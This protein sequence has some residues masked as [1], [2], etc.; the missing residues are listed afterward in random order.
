MDANNQKLENFIT[1]ILQIQNNERNKILKAK[2]LKDIAFEMGMSESEWQTISD[3][4]NAHALRGKGFL[5]YKNWGD[6]IKEF[7]Q[8]HTLNPYN[9]DILYGLA[10]SHKNLW[11]QTRMSFHKVNAEKY[12]QTCIGIDPEYKEAIALISAL[13]RPNK[14]IQTYTNQGNEASIKSRK[15]NTKLILT[16]LAFLVIAG[17]FGALLFMSS[18][19]DLQE[20]PKPESIETPKEITPKDVPPPIE[21]EE[22]SLDMILVENDKSKGIS[23]ITESSITSDYDDSYSVKAKGYFLLKDIE[24]D[25][26]K[27]KIDVLDQNNKVILTDVKKLIDKSDLIVRSGDLVPFDFLNY[28][29]EANMPDFKVIRLSV[30]YIKKEEGNFKYKASKPINIGWEIEKPTNFD[31]SIRERL[32]SIS[33]SYGTMYH[34]I[35]L[36]VENTGNST[37]NQLQLQIK[38]FNKQ[39]KVVKTEEIYITIESYSPLKRGTVYLYDRVFGIKELTLKTYKSYSVSVLS[40]K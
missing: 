20:T 8:A 28:V 5:E 14:R 9:T 13:K 3:T 18:E 30:N 11:L 34:K 36:E 33:E 37:I 35:V 23:L 15:A 32:V 38:W 22:P 19:Q 26:L 27:I 31:I 17:V 21:E 29:K 2:D 10:L 12:A 4:F 39:D 7:E 6:A 25:E 40:V 24:I 1:K 16:V